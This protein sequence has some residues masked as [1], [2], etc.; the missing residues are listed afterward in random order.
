MK[1]GVVDVADNRLTELAELYHTNKVIPAQI[2]FV[3]IAGL[4]K[5]ASEGAGLGNKFLSH[6]KEVDA[7]FGYATVDEL[8]KI[9]MADYGSDAAIVIDTDKVIVSAKTDNIKDFMIPRENTIVELKKYY[10]NSGE[11]RFLKIEVR[12]IAP[13]P[14]NSGYAYIITEDI[15]FKTLS[16][17]QKIT[18]RNGM[19]DKPTRTRV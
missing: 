2:E 12:N 10:Y 17:T 8:V 6:I 5:G 15:D 3:D 7:I 13:V 4:V 1:L 9:I 11:C 16:R 18:R 19:V 14:A